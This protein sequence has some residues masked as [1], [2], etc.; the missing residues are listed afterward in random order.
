VGAKRG[1]EQLGVELAACRV[2]VIGDTPKDVTAANGLG[3]AC[4]GVGTGGSTPA[5]LVALGAVCAFDTLAAEGVRAALLED[6]QR[7]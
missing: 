5:E 7:Q 3:A 2:V 6:E 1:A 4:V